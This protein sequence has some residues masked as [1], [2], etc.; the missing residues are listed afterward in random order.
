[1]LEAHQRYLRTGSNWSLRPGMSYDD[2]QYIIKRRQELKE[3]GEMSLAGKE[4]LDKMFTNLREEDRL[5]IDK[6][7]R[8]QLMRKY[9]YVWH[10]RPNLDWE[11]L[12]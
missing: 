6:L 2:Y 7:T 10:G 9:D 12:F 5:S 4:Y 1:M 3:Q 8:K 11:Y